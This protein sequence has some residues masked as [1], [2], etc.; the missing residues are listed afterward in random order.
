VVTRAKMKINTVCLRFNVRRMFIPLEAPS[1]AAIEKGD[2]M[3]DISLLAF[4]ELLV[5][6]E[7]SLSGSGGRAAGS[8]NP[9]E[10]IMLY[11]RRQITTLTHL[12]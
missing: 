1:S 2:P 11:L 7:K 5:G 8:G 12:V 3:L 10:V 9:P 4:P 6:G